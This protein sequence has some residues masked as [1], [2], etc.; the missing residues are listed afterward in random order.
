MSFEKVYTVGD[1]L[2]NLISP[3][4]VV[5]S[6]RSVKLPAGPQSVPWCLAPMSR[7][8]S[9]AGK[10]ELSSTS[11]T[12]DSLLKTILRLVVAF[13]AHICEGGSHRLYIK[14]AALQ[15]CKGC[16]LFITFFFIISVCR[17]FLLFT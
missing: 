7:F 12:D 1:L 9:L 13:L 14:T 15:V 8:L 16:S 11:G 4:S 6:A 3:S 10:L 2:V 17:P 5:T